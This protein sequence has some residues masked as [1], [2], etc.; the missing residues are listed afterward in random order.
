MNISLL[1]PIG[2]PEEKIKELAAGFA[3]AGHTFTYYD[4]KT[5]DMQELIRRSRGQDIVMIANNPYPA[6]VI[7]ECVDLKMIAVAFTGID[8]VGL[9]AC[10]E[11][12]ITV[13]N[14]AGYSNQSVAELAVGLAVSV[15][16]KVHEGDEAARCGRGSAGLTG[17]EICGKTV[18]IVGCG[19]IGFKTAMLFQAFG[20][21]VM[22]YSR[23]KKEAWEQAGLI[24]SELDT[25][26]SESDIISLHLPLNDTT[27]G[28][29]DS[30]K[31][32][33]MKPGSIFINC[34]RGPIVDNFALATALNEGLIGGAAI[35]VFD[36]EPPLP[37]NYPLCHSKNTL[38]TPHVAFATRE[39]MARRAEIEFKNVYAYL[40][41]KPENV[42]CN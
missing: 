36:M 21:R 28:I 31:I 3:A 42:C 15:M 14:C 4:V 19:Q 17:M 34:A 30:E 20:A 23:H 41:G 22:V 37:E 2:I 10:R 27:R 32:S 24:Y 7:R 11:K 18:G 16:R 1:E 39:A 6:E 9:E 33:K 35:D 13:C 38:L 25:L 26:L 29:I 8:H 12:G 5:T 40:E